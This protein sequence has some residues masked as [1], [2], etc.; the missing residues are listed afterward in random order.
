MSKEKRDQVIELA[1]GGMASGEIAKQLGLNAQQVYAMKN[2]YK[3]LIIERQAQLNGTRIDG[4][5]MPTVEREKKTEPQPATMLK[6]TA[7]AK[8]TKSKA[9][10]LRAARYVG[11]RQREYS[12]SSEGADVSLM[13]LKGVDGS[14]DLTQVQELIE[15]LR[16][17]AQ[18]M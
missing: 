10:R 3:G 4:T 9:T 14:Y 5:P 13:M 8:P 1:A 11:A 2:Q 15:E 7:R 16:E 17:L 18:M 12:W 6:M